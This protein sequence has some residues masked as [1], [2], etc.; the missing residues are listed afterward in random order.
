MSIMKTLAEAKVIVDHGKDNSLLVLE[1][2]K[3]TLANQIR[4]ALTHNLIA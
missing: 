1:D 2:I 4:N 3:K